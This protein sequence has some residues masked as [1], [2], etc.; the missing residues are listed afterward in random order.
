MAEAYSRPRFTDREGRLLLAAL[1]RW[2]KEAP[3]DAEIAR[4]YERLKLLWGD[5]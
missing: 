3:D 2:H 1:F 4:L 5:G